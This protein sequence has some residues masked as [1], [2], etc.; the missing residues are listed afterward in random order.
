MYVFCS[1]Q[2]QQDYLLTTPTIILE[3]TGRW[4]VEDEHLRELLEV[5]IQGAGAF[6]R[7]KDVLFRYPSAQE[8]WFKFRDERELQRMLN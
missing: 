5:A 8:N 6:R 2:F 4:S 3:P 7:F 1:Q